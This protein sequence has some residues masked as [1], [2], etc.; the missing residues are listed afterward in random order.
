MDVAGAVAVAAD[1]ELGGYGGS[2]RGMPPPP[3]WAATAAAA[4]PV[5]IPGTLP[6]LLKLGAC[7]TPPH[8][9]SGA[10]PCITIVG[11]GAPTAPP[12][13]L[14]PGGSAP[15]LIIPSVELP[16]C[17]WLTMLLMLLMLRFLCGCCG[18]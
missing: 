15:Q 3:T 6:W 17:P 2:Y 13:G 8:A 9:E 1:P 4:R 7:C 10:E 12:C 16:I 11:Q 5:N 18:W 14:A